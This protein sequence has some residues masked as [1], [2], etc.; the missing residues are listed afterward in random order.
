M[1]FS[2]PSE[3]SNMCGSWLGLEESLISSPYSIRVRRSGHGLIQLVLRRFS[4]CVWGFFLPLNKK[5][6]FVLV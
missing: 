3:M 4:E 2:L 5:K 6:T 1:V